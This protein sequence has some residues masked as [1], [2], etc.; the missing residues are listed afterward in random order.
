MMDELGYLK[1]YWYPIFMGGLLI[2]NLLI[3]YLHHM[4]GYDL[5]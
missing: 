5:D 3:L 4:E 1:D 2:Y